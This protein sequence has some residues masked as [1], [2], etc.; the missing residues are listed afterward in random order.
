MYQYFSIN[1]IISL[2]TFVYISQLKSAPSRVSFRF[3][4]I[5]LL[6]WLIPYDVINNYFASA[7]YTPLLPVLDEFRQSIKITLVTTISDKTAV[8]LLQ[9]LFVLSSLGLIIFIHDVTKLQQKIKTLNRQF[10]KTIWGIRVYLSDKIDGAF[11]FGIIRPKIFINSSL[12]NTRPFESVLSHEIQH[13]KQHDTIYTVIIAFIQRV[14][15]WNPLVP[16]LAR[17]SRLFIELNCD[18]KTALKIGKQTY[19][20]DLAG[21]LLGT[22]KNSKNNL[23]L[24]YFTKQNINLLRIKKLNQDTKMNKKHKS[25]IFSTAL[26]PLVISL[27]ISTQ[28]ISSNSS[29]GD[30]IATNLEPNQV[31]IILDSHIY[32]HFEYSGKVDKNGNKVVSSQDHR[33]IETNIISSLNETRNFNFGKEKEDVKITVNQVDKEKF[34]LDFD[35]TYYIDGQ[36]I[37]LTPSLLAINGKPASLVSNE[38]NYKF[39][40]NIKVI[41]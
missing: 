30:E 7:D 3:V 25:L 40:L 4:F 39:E 29:N 32:Y 1:V 6:S 14:L 8:N 38:D 21:L 5:A 37:N 24:S 2:L 36:K 34:M 27:L 15:W 23:V 16:P 19:Q 28:S 11:C 41:K 26:I 22:H 9:V 33:S 35:I 10:Y 20:K 12:K 17:Q 13:I 18:E 31:Q